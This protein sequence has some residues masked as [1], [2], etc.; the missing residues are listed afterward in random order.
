METDKRLVVN[1]IT[2]KYHIEFAKYIAIVS[3][4]AFVC[5]RCEFERLFL[6]EFTN[7]GRSV[8]TVLR[9]K[10]KSM[11]QLHCQDTLP[12]CCIWGEGLARSTSPKPLIY[13]R[14]LRGRIWYR[15]RALSTRRWA[16]TLYLWSLLLL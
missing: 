3:P 2:A 11:I 6:I 5:H 14:G 9:D 12:V 8:Y 10:A 1:S 4:G 16:I 13:P 15:A 7:I